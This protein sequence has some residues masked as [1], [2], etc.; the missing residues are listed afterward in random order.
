MCRD[1]ELENFVIVRGVLL[2]TD[3]TSFLPNYNPTV[4]LERSHDLVI[5][6]AGNVGHT[7]SS[8]SSAS[9]CSTRSSST[10]SRYNSIAS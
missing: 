3:M 8:K 2:E 9:D 6:K 10:G 5:S 7:T 4:S 1:G